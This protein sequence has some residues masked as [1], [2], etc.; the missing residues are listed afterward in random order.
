MFEGNFVAEIFDLPTGIGIIISFL[1]LTLLVWFSNT[2]TDDNY[3]KYSFSS[4]FFH[5]FGAALNQG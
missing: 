2:M 3:K 4:V 5:S 1:L